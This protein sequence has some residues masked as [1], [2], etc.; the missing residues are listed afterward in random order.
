[1]IAARP[2]SIRVR[3]ETAALARTRLCRSGDFTNAEILIERLI[4]L[5]EK[6]SFNAYRADGL[7]M[8]GELMIA[9]GEVDQGIVVL[10]HALP[11]LHAAEHHMRELA[12]L[13]A[14]AEGLLLSG[15]AQEAL[16]VID[17][18]IM[19]SEQNGPAFYTADMLRTRGEI[20]LGLPQ[21]DADGAEKVLVQSL[22]LAR[23]QCA[24]G[25]ELRSAISLARL[26]EGQS[27]WAEALY[28]LVEVSQ[29]F[30]EGF[31]MADLREATRMVR[32]F[33]MGT[34]PSKPVVTRG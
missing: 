34:A 13:R 6:Y 18:V 11:T 5:G 33:K 9:R 20:L 29:H 14:L 28:L 24:L 23:A 2:L 21:P 22:E 32:Q 8:K 12:G 31:D 4:A 10:R 16:T 27:R 30:T 3:I 15:Q 19:R 7:S 1:M 25:W 26:W 17:T